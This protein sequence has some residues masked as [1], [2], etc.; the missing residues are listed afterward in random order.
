MWFFWTEP[1]QDDIQTK[2]ERWPTLMFMSEQTKSAKSSH[3]TR[4]NEPYLCSLCI[5]RKYHK[6]VTTDTSGNNYIR[7]K[8]AHSLTT[9]KLL[10]KLFVPLL[11]AL[12]HH[13]ILF[14]TKRMTTCISWQWGITRFSLLKSVRQCDFSFK[15]RFKS[16]ASCHITKHVTNHRSVNSLWVQNSF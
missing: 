8:L 1:V 4:S 16:P 10:L 13:L 9:E 15:R 2:R 3:C 12:F 7:I 6:L 14:Y 11:G 5:C